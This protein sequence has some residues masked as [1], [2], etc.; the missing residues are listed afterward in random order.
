M[1]RNDFQQLTRIRLKEARVLLLN[2]HYEGAYYLAG[3]AVE[4]AIKACIAKNVKHYDFPDKKL[5]NESHSHDLEQLIKVAGLQNKLNIKLQV[6][7]QFELNWAIAKDWS[8]Q[9]RYSTLIQNTSAKDFY[10]ALTRRQHGIMT[11]LRSQW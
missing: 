5:A 7:R 11:W 3:Y 1:T 2:G 10:S 6:N 8:E 9:K 4:C